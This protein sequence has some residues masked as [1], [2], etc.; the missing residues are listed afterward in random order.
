MNERFDNA[1]RDWFTEM[2]VDQ[3]GSP[4]DV[5]DRATKEVTELLDVANTALQQRLKRELLDEKYKGKT[6]EEIV[7]LINNPTVT[8]APIQ[9]QAP[10][11]PP[12]E[13]IIV[14]D[15]PVTRLLAGIP[16]APNLVTAQDIID[17]QN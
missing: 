8:T 4:Q 1:L 10:V 6:T 11:T 12:T 7:A 14:E 3:D 16:Y 5:K 15:A 13:Q 2:N 17:A 9:E